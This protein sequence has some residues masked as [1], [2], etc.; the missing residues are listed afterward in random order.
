[1]NIVD[2]VIILSADE[3]DR[4]CPRNLK[5]AVSQVSAFGA[6]ICSQSRKLRPFLLCT[7]LLEAA[8]LEFKVLE[9]ETVEPEAVEPV[10]I[11]PGIPGRVELK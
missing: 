7:Q 6:D 11:E 3:A 8:G 5:W 4:S 10:T 9:P 1:M 2:G